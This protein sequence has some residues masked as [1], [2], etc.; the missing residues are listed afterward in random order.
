M[1]F[2][3]GMCSVHGIPL[4]GKD[5]KYGRG[6]WYDIKSGDEKGNKNFV[7]KAIHFYEQVNL[8]EPT[9]P[10]L[11]SKLANLYL[12][13]MGDTIKAEKHFSAAFEQD[14]TD[15][16]AA[17]FLA[18]IYHYH[19]NPHIALYWA[20]ISI[21]LLCD[22]MPAHMKRD[23]REQLESIKSSVAIKIWNW[24]PCNG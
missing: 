6:L 20:E 13:G 10:F 14:Q 2:K 22:D 17:Y 8:A 7:K 18:F 21:E 15:A 5:E 19:K 1:R 3:G 12:R 4:V 16:K 9:L 11:Q 23:Y 24:R